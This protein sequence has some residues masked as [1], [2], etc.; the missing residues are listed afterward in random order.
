MRPP[1]HECLYLDVLSLWICRETKLGLLEVVAA[2]SVNDGVGREMRAVGK[3]ARVLARIG[4]N[5]SVRSKGF[6]VR[7]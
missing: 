4:R 5:R 2:H 7:L 3:R 1:R 6:S